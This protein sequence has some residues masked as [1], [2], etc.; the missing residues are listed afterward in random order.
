MNILNDGTCTKHG[1]SWL[2][3][4]ECR[5][6]WQKQSTQKNIKKWEAVYEAYKP[7]QQKNDMNMLSGHHFL[8]RKEIE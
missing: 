7:S 3:C 8:T 2:V 5:E 6:A 4:H 1:L